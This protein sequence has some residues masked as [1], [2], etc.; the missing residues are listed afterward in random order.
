MSNVKPDNDRVP[1]RVPARISTIDAER[2]PGSGRRYFRASHEVCL[3]VSRGGVFIRTSDP[4]EPGRRLVVE[5]DLPDGNRFQAV[6]RVAWVTRRL[7]KDEPSQR[8]VGVQF[9]RGRA[10]QF[11]ALEAY[12][13]R[14]RAHSAR[15]EPG[16]R[17]TRS[18]G[19]A[20]GAKG[21][22]VE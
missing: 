7:G 3:N 5:L 16:A 6:G 13:A 20:A 4:L 12:L 18:T 21:A 11:S 17:S 8:G 10:D 1:V 22:H 2:D 15:A 9:L 19:P 14:I